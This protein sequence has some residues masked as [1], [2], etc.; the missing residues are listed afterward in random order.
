MSLRT[1][2]NAMKA[3]SHCV[4]IEI[5]GCDFICCELGLSILFWLD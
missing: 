2:F 3:N 1:F 4:F 5:V